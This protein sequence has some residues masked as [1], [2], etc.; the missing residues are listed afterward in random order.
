LEE[1]ELLLALNTILRDKDEQEQAIR[2]VFLIVDL[3]RACFQALV[4]DYKLD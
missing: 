4:L 3:E 1:D 2:A